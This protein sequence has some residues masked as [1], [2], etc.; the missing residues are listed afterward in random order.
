MLNLNPGFYPTTAPP[1]LTVKNQI[2]HLLQGISTTQDQQTM[3]LTDHGNDITLIGQIVQRLTNFVHHN[4][5]VPPAPHVIPGPQVPVDP[6]AGNIKIHPPRMFDGRSSE[7][8][9]F[10]NEM[11]DCVYLQRKD[12][13]VERDKCY[14]FGRYLKDGSLVD[15]FQNLKHTQSPLLE[16]FAAFQTQ[17]K[18][19][20]GTSDKTGLFLW[21]LQDH[22]QT[23]AV[24]SYISTFHNII[25]HLELSKQM[26]IS[27]F[28]QGLKEPKCTLN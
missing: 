7:V 9:G 26:K 1:A 24:H 17:F 18:V 16:N 5:T 13:K 14:Y 8:D 25:S 28:H 10:L 2:I 6:D 11:D 3:T 12:L 27:E 20:F 22:T 23:G 21:K 4:T 15:W 19:H